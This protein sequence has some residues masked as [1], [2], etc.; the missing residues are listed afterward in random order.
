MD[1]V[2]KVLLVYY[3]PQ[4]SGQ[5]AHVLSLAR[6]LDRQ[7]FDITVVLP[8]DLER[9]AADLMQAGAR[10]V[11][12]C[13]HKLVW[14][15]QAILGLARLVRELPADIVHIH[16]QEAGL[17]ARP[18]ARLA[19]AGAVLYTPQTIDVRRARWQGLYRLLEH[20]LAGITTAIASVNESDRRRLV[21][22]GIPAHKVVTVPNGIDLAAFE[23]PMDVAGQRGALGLD[24]DQLLVMQ[25]GRL[26]AQK[27]PVA[28]VEGA[29]H[30]VGQHPAVQFALVGDGP[31]RNSIAARVHQL[32]LEGK[33][34][35]LG[36]R[37]GASRLMAAADIVTLTSR[38]EGAPYALLEAMAWSRPVVSTAVNGCPEIV[39][40]GVTGLLV[41]AGD[42]AA[43]ARALAALLDD[44]EKS[45]AMGRLGRQRVEAYYALPQM[46]ARLERLYERASAQ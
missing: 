20:T 13:L 28:F 2:L 30:L 11:P 4:S 1:R 45:A 10:V 19:G 27:N 44:R 12:L 5:T 16:S 6:G 8:E 15:P 34:H 40:D 46:I 7:R 23:G 17:I 38:W 24:N 22:W 18:V 37:E 41:P 3:E 31:L 43:W 26:T 36:W 9:P 35:L 42:P 25:V 33:V 21:Q 39:A 32:G 14:H 29:A